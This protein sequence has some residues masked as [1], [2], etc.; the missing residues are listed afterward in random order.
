M[1]G[2]SSDVIKLKNQGVLLC[3]NNV[4]TLDRGYFDSRDVIKVS[5]NEVA[6]LQGKLQQAC[7]G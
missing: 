1:T 3:K 7:S 2:D 6:R 5:E 4:K